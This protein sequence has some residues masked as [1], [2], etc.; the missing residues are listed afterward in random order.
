MWIVAVKLA[1][2][3]YSFFGGDA[4][5]AK[6]YSAK[7]KSRVVLEV[8]ESERSIPEVAREYD[9]HSNTVRNWVN[10]LKDNIEEV[11]NK[12]QTIKELKQ[13]NRELE[14]LLG[15]KEREIALLKN[16]LE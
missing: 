3:Q 1:T 6:R 2:I 13:E 8:L 4:P 14:Q 15:K 11:F 12:D 7:V 10:Q 16:F 5:M 9:V